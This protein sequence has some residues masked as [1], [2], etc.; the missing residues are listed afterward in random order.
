MNNQT[1]ETKAIVPTGLAPAELEL[2][3]Q[4]IEVVKQNIALC[5]QLVQDVLEEDIDYGT[6]P[7]VPTP[8]LW[9][10]GAA[11]IMAA[12]NCYA[13]YKVIDA[14]IQIPH[15]RYT[16]MSQLVSRKTQQIVAT[17]IGAA[18][19]KEVKHRYRWVNDP[20][21]DGI[22][23]KGLKTRKD[24]KYRIPN[25]DTEDLLNTIAKMAA[26]RADVDAAQS[27][28]GVAATLRKLFL[29]PPVEKRDPATAPHPSTDVS[30]L[31]GSPKEEGPNWSWFWAKLKTIQ[32]SAKEAH[33][34]LSVNSIKDDWLGVQHRTLEEAYDIISH[35]VNHAAASK[36][37]EGAKLWPISP[38]AE[39]LS[40][41]K[42]IP[43][44]SSLPEDKKGATAGL[45]PPTPSQ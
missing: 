24:G 31:A 21:A 40:M 43:T 19:T 26:K 5:Q 39:Q 37:Q 34:I 6:I 8:F 38:S 30:A 7:G 18:S 14:S 36:T 20:E 11:K 2:S 28:P 27:L 35:T 42:P 23:R 44:K 45:S 29:S 1:E 33:D 3:N 13:D 15:I 9:D 32:V 17:G 4:A 10:S 22:S 12:F 41:T 16:I 25:P